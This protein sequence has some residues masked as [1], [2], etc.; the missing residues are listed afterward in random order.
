MGRTKKILLWLLSFVI[1]A[2]VMV[3]QRM[4]GPTYPFRGRVDL[5]GTQVKFEL[6]RSAVNTS[7]CEVTVNVPAGDI[8][9]YIEWRR[10]RTEDPWGKKPLEHKD[11][12][13]TALLPKQPMAGKLAYR[14]ILVENEKETLLSGANPVVIRFRGNVPIYVVIPHVLAMLF[15][16]MFS[17]RAGLAA[18][19][20]KGHP[21]TYAKWTA[22]VFFIAGFVL[23]PMMN[24]FAFGILWEGFPLGHDLT[25]TK[26]LVAMIGWIVALRAGRKGKPAR[27]WV[28]GASVLLLIVFLIPHSVLGTELDYTKL[29]E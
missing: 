9:G 29:P 27:A 16:L 21:G 20:K 12:K 23:G 8:S 2:A 11:G 13:L 25:D 18:I 3:Y 24:S 6:P 14:V 28:L 26:S 7:D 4:T 19:D 5:A 10:F 1:A 15:A 22:V 17:M